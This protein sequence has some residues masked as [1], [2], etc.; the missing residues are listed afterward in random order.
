MS[1]AVRTV[2]YSDEGHHRRRVTFDLTVE[3]YRTLRSRLDALIED[4][5]LLDTYERERAR[6]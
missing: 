1:D 6:G 3:Q 2:D 4:A 5:H